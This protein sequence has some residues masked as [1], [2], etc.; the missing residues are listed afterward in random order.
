MVILR[1]E[2]VYLSRQ[3]ARSP[4]LVTHLFGDS[5]MN[6]ARYSKEALDSLP[7]HSAE[8][9]RRMVELTTDVKLEL[10]A[11]IAAKFR[12]M[13]NHL[14]ALG[15][16][17]RED[18]RSN[19]GDIDYAEGERPNPFYLCCDTTISAGY[20]S[21]SACDVPP[22]NEEEWTK[23]WANAEERQKERLRF[24]AIG[25]EPGASPSGSPD[26]S[27]GNSGVT[28]EPPSVS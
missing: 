4:D 16:D 8:L 15:H 28:E 27:L 24:R 6:Y 25:S 10:H 19:P 2:V 9:K 5:H 26:R 13:V 14:N 3:M 21:T 22:E 18:S 17:L 7:P 20:R 1:K 23:E 11:T 12:E